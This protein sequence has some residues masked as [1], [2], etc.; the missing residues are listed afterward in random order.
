MGVVPAGTF[1]SDYLYWDTNVNSYRVGSETVHLG[2]NAGHSA[3]GTG[4][5]ALGLNAGNSNQGNYSI[6]I[7]YKAGETSQSANSIILNASGNTISSTNQGFYV[8]PVRTYT[9]L[10]SLTGLA[11]DPTTNEIVTQS[12]KTFVIQH[13]LYEDRFLVHACLEGPE[14]GVYYRSESRINMDSN[15][16][17]IFLPEYVSKIAN[18]FSIQI[19]QICEDSDSE[20]IQ[21]KTSRVKN[22]SFTVYGKPNS[23]FYWHVYGKRN[24]IEI[25]PKKE[26][27]I[28]HSFGPYTYLG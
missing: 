16:V 23:S 10:S 17:T 18:S 19:T 3:Q 20:F 12:N 5:I 13:P 1:Y 8:N 26:K 4:C 2:Q 9:G 15:F 7:G 21:F 24:E 14:A 22:N 25:E 28:L 6:A 27:T 11:Y